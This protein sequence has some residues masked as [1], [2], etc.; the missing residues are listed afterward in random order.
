MSTTSSGSLLRARQAYV[1]L[2]ADKETL[3][4]GIAFHSK[5]WSRLAS[6]S[7][8]REVL[9]PGPGQMSAVFESVEEFFHEQGAVCR[10]WTPSI[11]QPADVLAD[12]LLPR[13]YRQQILEVMVLLAHQ[14]LP[15]LPEG[16]RI[17]PARPMRA[18]Y[19]ETFL[20]DCKSDD[21]ELGAEAALARLNEP[22]LNM[23][24]AMANDRPVGRVGLFEVG[25]IGL[26]L[27][28]YVVPEGY[29]EAYAS[30]LLGHVLALSRRLA[31]RRVC[32][33]I[34]ADDDP[35]IDQLKRFG[36]VADGQVRQFE[37]T[38]S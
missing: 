22:S 30:A 25:D 35:G 15:A 10:R 38:E 37:R 34:E 16:L 17:L 8:F 26:I 11:A 18:A 14:E 9:L 12:F 24:V 3:D 28:P 36:F 1:E 29:S 31:C 32:L 7:Q 6:A 5:E 2:L 21:S 19:R 13:G 4:G 23:F 33:Q 20:G 27:A